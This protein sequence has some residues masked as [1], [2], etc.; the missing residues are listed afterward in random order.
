MIT[1]KQ[2][3]FSEYDAMRQLYVA[4]DREGL[5]RNRVIGVIDQSAL[6]PILKGNNIVIEKFTQATRVFGKDRYRMYL[7][8]GAKAKMPDDVRLPQY[9]SDKSLGNLRLDLNYGI[10]ANGGDGGGNNQ[11][12]DQNKQNQNQQGS[13]STINPG[14]KDK[15]KKKKDKD[16][17]KNYSDTTVDI[18]FRQK[19]FATPVVG[20]SFRPSV[21]FLKYQIHTLLGDA[22][23]YDKKER[24]L[25]LE[26]SSIRD[27][28]SALN[29]LPF[30]LGYKIYLL[31]S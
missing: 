8:V 5:I 12:G 2:K 23:K 3:Q 9:T 22:L 28:I 13:S 31:N 24:S 19:Q 25:V 4:L 30:G 29:I 18:K 21:D 11:Q 26:F 20:V 14:P 7:K 6:I 1:F 16:S 15:D 17:P 10:Y 27:A